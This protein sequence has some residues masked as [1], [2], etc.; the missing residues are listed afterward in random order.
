MLIAR[1]HV[2]MQSYRLSNGIQGFKGHVVNIEQDV[3]SFSD[4]LQR[5]LPHLPED[6]PATI[7]RKA[8]HEI[9]TRHKDFKVRRGAI[10]TWPEFL[11]KNHPSYED[12]RIDLEHLNCLPLDGSVAER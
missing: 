9:P 11:K 5:A 3:S 12:T 6:L 1:V 2:V 10:L 8:H 4:H 7:V